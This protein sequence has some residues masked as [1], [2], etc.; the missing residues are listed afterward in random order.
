MLPLAGIKGSAELLNELAE[1]ECELQDEVILSV[2]MIEVEYE[3]PLGKAKILG[4]ARLSEVIDAG[5]VTVVANYAQKTRFGTN[6]VINVCAP[7]APSMTT[8]TSLIVRPRG[9][10][11]RSQ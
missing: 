9:V 3:D 8:T 2:S 4:L 5:E 10:E 7:S 11:A 1:F 6:K